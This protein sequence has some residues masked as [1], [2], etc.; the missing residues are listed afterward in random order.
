[1]PTETKPRANSTARSRNDG[2]RLLVG[3]EPWPGIIGLGH[4]SFED[5]IRQSSGL[6]IRMGKMISSPSPW[7]PIHHEEQRDVRP[8]IC[9]QIKHL[10]NA[11]LDDQE[12]RPVTRD[13]LD[14]AVGIVEKF[15]ETIPLPDV[16][17]TP[18][19]HVR[20]D[21]I[22]EDEFDTTLIMVVSHDSM[23]HFVYDCDNADVRIDG[24]E[25]WT[26]QFES[27]DCFLKKL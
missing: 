7:P 10:C 15:P 20:L 23:I 4:E 17:A 16:S 18:E 12:V 9:E 26:G 1:M 3:G 24:K 27:I 19:G 21:W 6:D 2:S 11:Y 8:N 22:M 25:R 5:K 13:L 14:L